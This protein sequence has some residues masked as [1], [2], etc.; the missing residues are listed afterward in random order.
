MS[1]LSIGKKLAGIDIRLGI[2]PSRPQFD[3]GETNRRIANLNRTSNR[4]SVYNL[5]RS[6]IGAGEGFARPANFMVTLIGPKFSGF[7]TN[8]VTT[9]ETNMKRSADLASLLHS[10]SNIVMDLFC[11][12]VNLPERTITD[13]VNEQYYGASRAIAKNMSF[14][15]LT[16]SFYSSVNYEER[17]FFEAWQNSIVDP[18]T[19][20]VGYYD[21]YAKHCSVIITP[22]T[23]TFTAAL[24]NFPS[25]GNA[26]MDRSILNSKLASQSGESAYQV[27]CLEAWP[28]TINAVPLSYGS[29]NEIVK[30][31]VTIKFREWVS[32]AINYTSGTNY[33][34]LAKL[35]SK[36]NEYRSNV[37]AIRGGLL[38]NLPFGIGNVIGSVGRQVYEKVKRDIPIGRVTGGRVF[39]KGL[40]D[41]K[42]IRDLLY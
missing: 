27:Q 17:V 20:N 26:A 36:R 25:S 10:Q 24:T 16:L 31:T 14:N 1:I 29:T 6:Q 22:L 5:F 33:E 9:A 41:P 40:P 21:D 12:E 38:D 11:F 28:K 32:T 34:T 15:E 2:P 30:M 23:K 35:S 19:Y 37:E 39:P 4:N 3:V 13:E 42:V 7:P 8:Q 18:A